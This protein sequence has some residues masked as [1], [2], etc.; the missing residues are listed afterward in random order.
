M[1]GPA[2]APDKNLLAK[3]ALALGMA[4]LA[5]ACKPVTAAQQHEG[6]GFR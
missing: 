3:S 1:K 5:T 2:H 4:L 6:I